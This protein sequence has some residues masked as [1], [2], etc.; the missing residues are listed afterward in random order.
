VGVSLPLS[1]TEA[2][3]SKPAQLVPQQVCVYVCVRVCMCTCVF[4]SET[5]Q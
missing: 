1:T 4:A 3:G 5:V 2:A